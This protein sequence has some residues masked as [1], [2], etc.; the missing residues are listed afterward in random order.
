MPLI[1]ATLKNLDSNNELTLPMN[2]SDYT[3]VKQFQ[4]A[5]ESVIGSAEPIVAFQAGIAKAISMNFHCDLDVEDAVKPTDVKSFLE[6]LEKVN[7]DTRSVP[8]VL[9][10]WG[11]TIFK[12]YVSQY[13]FH[14]S[15]FD[16]EGKIM[17]AD[18]SLSLM[19]TRK[20]ENER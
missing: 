15:R 18:V 3:V 8:E 14:A 17:S 2:P 9:F 1:K 6:G 16:N 10:S 20:G 5:S 11:D 12:G 4:Y 19:G 13:T 7:S